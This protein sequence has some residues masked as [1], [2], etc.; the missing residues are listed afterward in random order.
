[1]SSN[2]YRKDFPLLENNKVIYLDNAATSQRP[3]AVI[4][5][6]AQFY[7]KYNANPL[8]GLYELSVEATD[9]Y[10]EARETV[11]KFIG[12]GST[13]EIIFTRNTTEG[14]N[15]VAYSYG[16]SHLKAG[17]EVLV[18]IMEHHSN[19]LPWQMVCRQTGATLKFLE[20]DQTGFLSDETLEN[21]ITDKTRL[22]AIAQVSN[23]L[24]RTAPIEK[25]VKLARKHGAVVVMDA[26]QSAPHMPINV[27]DLDVDFMAFSG[28]KLMGPMGIGVLYGKKE[29]LESMPPFL[30]GGEMIETVSR[31][32]ATYAELPHKFEAG[33]VNA[34]GAVALAEAIRYMQKLGMS[35]VQQAEQELTEYLLRGMQSIPHI[36]VLGS[37]QAENHTGI[38]AFTV[39]QVH[40]HD[41]SEIL[42]SDGMDIRAGHHCAEPLHQYLGIHSSARASV[43][44]YNTKEEADRFLESVSNIRRRMGYGE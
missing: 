32:D 4:Q 36:H 14:L 16:F 44:F 33:T 39:D 37:E 28:H 2:P 10:E 18:S 26:A 23:V 6:E 22:V 41:I 25:I 19:L 34:G 29:L 21:A 11:R 9:C 38:V 20:C 24:G 31:Y 17:D 15:L 35:N 43:M 27:K 40:P 7:E 12:A 5:A 8:R 1:M 13:E 42:S 3:E 30:T